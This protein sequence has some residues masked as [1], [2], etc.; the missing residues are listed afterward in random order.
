MPEFVIVERRDR[1]ATAWRLLA[2]RLDSPLV[3][4]AMVAVRSPHEA[5]DL[6][7]SLNLAE[8]GGL[9]LAVELTA[10]MCD[11][12]L[13][14]L[15]LALRKGPRVAS[16]VLAESAWADYEWVVRE[17]GAIELV[18]GTRGLAR[19]V[20]AARRHARRWPPAAASPRA[21]VWARLPWGG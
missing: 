2:E 14:L 10:P 6:L 13:E 11:A 16:V 20:E 17:L 4:G 21:A 8:Q 18:T 15:A 19:A 9:V 3:E 12:A 5:R 7:E 1:W